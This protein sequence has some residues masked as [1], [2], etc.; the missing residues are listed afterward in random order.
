MTS[1]SALT[2]FCFRLDSLSHQSTHGT[3]PSLGA[4]FSWCLRFLIAPHCDAVGIATCCLGMQLHIFVGRA[5]SSSGEWRDCHV[6]R[7]VL[8]FLDCVNYVLPDSFFYWQPVEQIFPDLR[9]ESLFINRFSELFMKAGG[10][11]L[12]YW[13]TVRA[14]VG[15]LITRQRIYFQ[16]LPISFRQA[17]STCICAYGTRCAVRLSVW[18]PRSKWKWAASG[19]ADME[20]LDFC[21]TLSGQWEDDICVG[22]KTLPSHFLCLDPPKPEQTSWREQ[23]WTMA[24]FLFFSS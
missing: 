7:V 20:V 14:H 3:Q 10:K 22:L 23:T 16:F 8:G 17:L 24:F 4:P 9:G 13:K 18:A 6:Y 11:K 5:V 15:K 2:G 19:P 21:C 12:V 1:Y